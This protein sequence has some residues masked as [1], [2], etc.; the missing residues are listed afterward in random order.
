MSGQSCLYVV[1]AWLFATFAVALLAPDIGPGGWVLVGTVFTG[2]LLWIN[3]QF[4]GRPRS[5]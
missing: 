1:F 2:V 5:E 3:V 4:A